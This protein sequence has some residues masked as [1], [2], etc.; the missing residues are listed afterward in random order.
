VPEPAQHPPEAARVYAVV[1][2][3][4]DD[5]HAAGDAELAECVCKCLRIGQGVASIRPG[6]GTRE[7]A[8]QVCVLRTGNVQV[9]VFMLAPRLVVQLVAAIDDCKGRIAEVHSERS[10]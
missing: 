10:G 7:I 6:F 9:H 1:L 5:L 2:I 4:G 3:V 8:T